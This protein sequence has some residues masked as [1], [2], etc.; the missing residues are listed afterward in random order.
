MKEYI[1]EKCNAI[2]AAINS[3]K[4]SILYDVEKKINDV[5]HALIA[6]RMMELPNDN[7]NNV[8]DEL[9]VVFPIKTM[10]NFL[11][12]E[13]AIATSQEKKKALVSKN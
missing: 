10:E 1:D 11:L 2:L 6:S 12:F 5:K 7:I 13:E 9:G 8:K 4:R 3:A